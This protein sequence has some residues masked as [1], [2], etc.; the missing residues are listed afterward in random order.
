MQHHLSEKASNA[1]KQS[2]HQDGIRA[3]PTRCGRC[4]QDTHPTSLPTR[5]PINRADPRI[6]QPSSVCL[7][8]RLINNL[9]LIDL[10]NRIRFLKM[11]REHELVMKSDKPP[12]STE[13]TICSN[14]RIP[15]AP[16]SSFRAGPQ[17]TRID[18]RACRK[19]GRIGNY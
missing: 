9:G 4:A 16:P 19:M 8:C 6:H 18:V 15:T 7:M 12:T 17:S 1:D 14:D 11:T 13:R 5:L 10:C 2:T 3:S